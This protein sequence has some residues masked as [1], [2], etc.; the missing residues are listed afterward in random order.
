[1]KFELVLKTNDLELNGSHNCNELTASIGFVHYVVG[2]DI[3]AD[4]YTKEEIDEILKQYDTE[5]QKDRQNIVFK[6]DNIS[7][8]TNDVG[9]LTKTAL[10]DYQKIVDA[11][12]KYQPKGNYL[13]EEVEP[14]YNRD[15][16]TLAK[17]SDIPTKVS[18]LTND[19][20]YLTEHQS[21]ANYALKSEVPQ[22][23][24]VKD[25][26]Q[27]GTKTIGFETE[28]HYGKVA[29]MM[30]QQSAVIGYMDQNAQLTGNYSAIQLIG[31]QINIDASDGVFI[32]KIKLS[33]ETIVTKD[34]FKTIN[35]E[36]IVG[37]GDI[38]IKASE[39]KFIIEY[40]IDFDTDE[41]YITSSKEDLNAI[42]DYLEEN[43]TANI[44]LFDG[45]SYVP[46]NFI[47]VID[48]SFSLQA[49]TDTIVF[50]VNY[51]KYSENADMGTLYLAS[52]DY[53]EQEY[54]TKTELDALL[55]EITAVDA[56]NYYNKAEIDN[57]IGD[58][59]TLLSA[60]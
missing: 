37:E 26:A 54:Y 17:K 32:N 34:S 23:F 5:Y 44:Y 29:L 45:E 46:V 57:K 3:M 47:N 4:Y 33:D 60:L 42:Y 53:L 24:E 18:E 52:E 39:E 19:I 21:L 38:E 35:G 51:D 6:R 40:G 30:D 49:T 11:D 15:K 55:N 9:Y 25:K 43:T 14:Q 58:I 28:D 16:A 13:T 41:Y 59:E 7:N 2:S 22:L 10:T 27:W 20:G 56:D 12:N 31:S 1:M 8:L 50:Y 48:G 36:A